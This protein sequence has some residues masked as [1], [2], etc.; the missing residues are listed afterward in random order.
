ML[1]GLN[2]WMRV[3]PLPHISP[4]RTSVH[5]KVREAYYEQ[6]ELGWDNL[7]RGRFHK[8]WEEAQSAFQVSRGNAI[9]PKMQNLIKLLWDAAAAM[10]KA[11]NKMEHGTTEDAQILYATGRMEAQ[12]TEMYKNKKSVSLAARI[13]LF[14]IPLN[15][16]KRYIIQS[17]KRWLE[18]VRAAVANK[19]RH[20]EKNNRCQRSI[21]TFLLVRRDK[22]TSAKSTTAQPH[23]PRKYFQG[24]LEHLYVNPVQPIEGSRTNPFVTNV[25][26]RKV[27]Y[28]I[29]TAFFKSRSDEQ[30]E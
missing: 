13:Q 6:D 12:L 26:H 10:W 27:R 30:R 20:D 16:R 28:A 4:K 23:V 2:A 18:M 25:I 14:K 3:S 21:L 15:K 17:N 22:R 7:L 9:S 1:K 5:K 29:I 19:K 11:R 24:N 8:S